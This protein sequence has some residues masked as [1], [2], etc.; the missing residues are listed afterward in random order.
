MSSILSA[1]LLHHITKTAS[2]FYCRR[3]FWIYYAQR[4][5]IQSKLN[6]CNTFCGHENNCSS[7][8]GIMEQKK[9][10]FPRLK[11]R[12]WLQSF[13][14]SDTFFPKV[15][16]PDTV[17]WSSSSMSGMLSK[18]IKYSWTWAQTQRKVSHLYVSFSTPQILWQIKLLT[19][20]RHWESEIW[21]HQWCNLWGSGDYSETFLEEFIYFTPNFSIPFNITMVIT[22]L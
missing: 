4:R 7:H 13:T 18:R 12:I 9:T 5:Y 3:A 19:K 10:R 6:S 2:F 11:K 20:Y 17:R 8:A 21:G 1:L 15:T 16:S 14:L 22:N